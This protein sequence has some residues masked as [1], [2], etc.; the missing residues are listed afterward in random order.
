MIRVMRGGK[1]AAQRS[2]AVAELDE[3][4][5]WRTF[6]P[7]VAPYENFSNEMGHQVEE[8]TGEVARRNES[9]GASTKNF[10]DAEKPARSERRP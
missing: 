1:R 9:C 7:P 6:E 5:C 2:G 3:I 4:G 10:R 8:A